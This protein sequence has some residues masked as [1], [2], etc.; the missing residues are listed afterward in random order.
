MKFEFSPQIFEKYSNTKFREKSLQWEQ[1]CSMRNN[2][3]TERDMTKL[4]VT[5]PCLANA[6]KNVKNPAFVDRLQLT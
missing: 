3:R 6:P 5:F 1:G 2:R 4:T